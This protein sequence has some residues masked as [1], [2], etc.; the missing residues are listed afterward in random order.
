MIKIH[1]SFRHYLLWDTSRVPF[2]ISTFC[3]Q[4]FHSLF[5]FINLWDLNNLG[6]SQIILYKIDRSKILKGS[7]FDHFY[8]C[9]QFHNNIVLFKFGISVIDFMHT[10]TQYVCTH[11]ICNMYAIMEIYNYTYII[12]MDIKS[13]FLLVYWRVSLL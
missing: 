9:C 5:S 13:F 7:Y 12:F 2:Q 11:F 6:L 10:C 3:S 1:I 4:D 8:L